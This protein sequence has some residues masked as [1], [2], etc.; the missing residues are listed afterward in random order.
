MVSA[1][2]AGADILL[3][4]FHAGYVGVVEGL[5]FI[6]VGVDDLEGGI[7]KIAQRARGLAAVAKVDLNNG[8][9]AI[10]GEV[11]FDL[12]RMLFKFCGGIGLADWRQGDECEGSDGKQ[13]RVAA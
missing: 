1:L 13:E 5:E 12:P 3:G 9:G 4:P 6:A 10:F 11:F 2:G 7:G 8:T